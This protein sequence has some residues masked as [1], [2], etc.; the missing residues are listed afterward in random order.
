MSV[1]T[2]TPPSDRLIHS[3]E[4]DFGGRH[5]LTSPVHLMQYDKSLPLVAVKL[6]L[7][8]MPFKLSNGAS[9]NLR[10]GKRDG[11]TVYNPVLGCD[12]SRTMVYCEM[13]KQICS[14]YGP[15]PAIL[16]LMI[17]ENIAGSSYLL[18]DI[19]KNPVQE[20][21]VESSNEY[22]T[23]MEVV[24]DAKQALDKVPIIQNGTFWTW[25]TSTGAYVDTGI[26]AA[27]EQ[28]DTG[29]GIEDCILNDDY[30]LTINF[31]DGSSYT[32]PSIRGPVGPKGATGTS[33]ASTV[34]NDDYTLTIT[35]SDGTSYTTPS[36]RGAIGPKGEAGKGLK[37]LGYF[38]T[39]AALASGVTNP[40][41]GDAYGVGS[42]PPYDI[43]MWDPATSTWVNNGPLQGAK[44]NDGV[45]F[46]P[47]VS[48]DGTLNWTNNGGLAN[49]EPVNIRGPAGKDGN[50]GTNGKDGKDAAA[51]KTLGLTGTSVGQIVKIKAVDENGK[52]TAWESVDSSSLVGQSAQ[53]QRLALEASAWTP[54][55]I[56]NMSLYRLELT[57]AFFQGASPTCD[58]V[59]IITPVWADS[60]VYTAFDVRPYEMVATDGTITFYCTPVDGNPPSD[61]LIVDV[62]KIP[63]L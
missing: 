21:S 33:I 28:G 9:V 17:G 12:V 38:S 20:G 25:D 60:Y 49:P 5:S 11:T 56:N 37:I 15:T 50:N 52:P 39:S 45:S 63:Y 13:T 53:S 44:G 46:T 1:L 41:A 35:L 14:E 30:T 19:A 43:Y 61:T 8:G 47:N 55:D 26:S 16:E 51:D 7:N 10:V 36:I 27:G 59:Y 31:T 3:A 6:Y 57:D 42:T 34:L 2:Y 24:A 18:L 40:E 22:K 48:A 4:V 54:E 29:N 23:I 62:L 32:T 58:Y